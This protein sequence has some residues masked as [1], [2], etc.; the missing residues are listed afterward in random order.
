[1]PQGFLNFKLAPTEESITSHA[2]LALFGEYCKA[3]GLQKMVNATFPKPGS[4]RGYEAFSHLFAL[5]LMLHDGG[6]ELSDIRHIQN[7]RAL[8]KILKL[9]ALPTSDA[10]NKW[11]KR[12]QH[13]GIEALSKIERLLLGRYLKRIKEPLVLDIDASVIE[14]HKSTA[15]CT[16]KGM[17]GYTPMF[18]HIN[19]GYL[20]YTEFRAGNVA[21]SAENLDFI[22]TCI[23]RLPE[24]KKVQ[25]L[26][27]DSAS[28]QAEILNYCEAHHITFTIGGKLDRATLETIESIKQWET[29]SSKTGA[30][31]DYEEQVA[32]VLHTMHDAHHAFR[33]IVIK[34]R[35]TP[36]LPGIREYLDE[37]TLEA[38][39]NEHYHVIATNADEQIT[40]EEIVHFYRQRGESSEN[41][42]KAFKRGFNLDYLPTSDFD[43]NAFYF[44]IGALAYNLFLLFSSML[45]S[46]W[47]KHQVET[48]R[49]KLYHL[50]GRL[51]VHARTLI[52]KVQSDCYEMMLAIRQRIMAEAAEPT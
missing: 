29:L 16:Y 36:L 12:Y 24:N 46:A 5:V 48:I 14:S 30:F 22:K 31:H 3:I 45:E 35:A 7:D 27:A 10:I 18:G 15:F 47:Q 4:N 6:R 33:L 8:R 23:Q 17:P 51:I 32:E 20:L 34:K 26:R 28:Y 50:A 38:Y 42:I 13:K 41:K 2:G 39:A 37:A 9:S 25:Y 52:L 21:P 19:G 43:A 44:H 1:M 40:A 49:Y 11:L